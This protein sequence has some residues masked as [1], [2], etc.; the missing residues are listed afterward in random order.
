MIED[1]LRYLGS[2]EVI[3]DKLTQITEAFVTFYGEDKRSEIEERFKNTL[4]IRFMSVKS[5][6]QNVRLFKESP[7]KELYGIS[8]EENLGFNIEFLLSFLRKKDKRSYEWVPFWVKK[9]LFGNAD[10]SFEEIISKLENGE[11]PKVQELLEKYESIA[12]IVDSFEKLI[13]MEDKKRTKIMEKYYHILLQEFSY[14]IPEEEKKSYEITGFP[15]SIMKGYFGWSIIDNGHC[16]DDKHEEILHNANAKKYDKESIID[17]RLW[18]LKELGY[19]FATYEEALN[20]SKCSEVIKN[21]RVVCEKI[22][23]RKSQLYPE[24]LIEITHFLDDYEK[25]SKLISNCQYVDKKSSLGP[26]LY[27]S[28]G[29]SCCEPKYIFDG[30]NYILSPLVLINGGTLEPDYT[31]IHELNH[32]FEYHTIDINEDGYSVIS[33]WDTESVK[34]KPDL[35]CEYGPLQYMGITR[36]YELLS[37]YVNERIAQE[38][39]EIMHEQGNYILK[40]TKLSEP[41]SYM[42]VEFLLEDF[43]QQFKD[44]IIASR[45]NGNITYLYDKIGKDN[46]EALNDLTN[47]VY[48]RYGLDRGITSALD[49]Y[50]ENKPTMDT[51][52]IKD[53]LMRRDAILAKMEEH[54]QSSKTAD[55]FSR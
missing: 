32:A 20:D 39:T 38:I 19:E 30:K 23:R 41:A 37:E 4:I 48:N 17:D 51:Q 54:L 8:E 42:K 50:N 2:S 15:E 3:T 14:L 25:C 21:L 27:E 1:R 7:L 24:Q 45:S 16:F 6:R 43:Y 44:I 55:S 47:E 13:D 36:K 11:Y 40:K 22:A 12:P 18:F 31:I 5:L 49:D 34:F 29:V 28:F 9:M 33:G 53:I 35:K 10:F 26:I 46:F 52:I